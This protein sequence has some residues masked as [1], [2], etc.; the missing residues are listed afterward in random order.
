MGV[1]GAAR[2]LAARGRALARRGGG[3]LLVARRRVA[4]GAGEGQR[5]AECG[6]GGYTTA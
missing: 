6:L 3:A 4:R 2:A 5:G 1:S